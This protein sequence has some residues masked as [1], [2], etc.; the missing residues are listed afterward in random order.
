MK[1]RAKR[2]AAKQCD[3]DRP[4][5]ACFSLVAGSMHGSPPNS[6]EITIVGRGSRG[7]YLWIGNDARDAAGVLTDGACFATLSGAKALR[8]LA[9]S[10]LDA[11][12]AAK[13]GT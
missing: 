8:A 1:A 2:Y 10:I 9:Q 13:A 7:V 6:P 11:I 12:P 4:D 5:A 3:P